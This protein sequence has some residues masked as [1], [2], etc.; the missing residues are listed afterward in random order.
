M[1]STQMDSSYCREIANLLF[2]WTSNIQANH[3]WELMSYESI[4]DLRI[5]DESG[6]VK[7][8]LTFA[9]LSNKHECSLLQ[10]VVG[11]IKCSIK[12]WW[13]IRVQEYFD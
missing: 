11:S 3:K 9:T 10:F 7:C 1:V 12:E 8:H 4:K 6:A 13:E 5:I 2:K